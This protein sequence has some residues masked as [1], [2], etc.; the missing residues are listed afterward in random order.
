MN[1]FSS[2]YRFLHEKRA[3]L[4][5]VE[6]LNIFAKHKGTSLDFELDDDQQQQT[7]AQLEVAAKSADL[8]QH[9]I[10]VTDQQPASSGSIKHEHLENCP[11]G[12]QHQLQHND[13]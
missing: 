12:G 10:D 8:Q 13:I 2:S 11:L 1:V 4:D 7:V 9:P 3:A 5:A 6:L